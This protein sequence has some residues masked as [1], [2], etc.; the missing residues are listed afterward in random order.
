MPLAMAAPATLLLQ[1]RRPFVE[2]P[3][4][5]GNQSL[6]PA[7]LEAAA[8]EVGPGRGSDPSS[9][10][11]ARAILRTPRAPA[12]VLSFSGSCS[13]AR[14][15]LGGGVS[16]REMGAEVELGGG[17]TG[18]TGPAASICWRKKSLD[19]AGGDGR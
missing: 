16:G 8:T 2:V 10:A 11:P 18:W 1:A 3:E 9:A 17:E 15:N 6:R 12:L 13:A 5:P 14:R 7:D 19:V 4:A